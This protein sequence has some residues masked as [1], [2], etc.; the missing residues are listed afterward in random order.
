M[1]LF[2]VLYSLGLSAKKNYSLRRQKHLPCKVISLGNLTVGGTGK[3]PAAIAVAEEALKRGFSSVILTRGYK[4]SAKGPCFVSRGDVPLLNVEEAGD[5]PY[6]MAAR[7]R[8]VPVVKGADR[9]ASGLFAIKELAA[10]STTSKDRLLFILDDGFQHW[11]LYRDKDIV[12]IDSGDPFGNG[13]LLPLGRLREPVKAVGRA[14]IIVITKNA[15]RRDQSGKS[16]PV[17]DIIRQYNPDAPVHL[18]SHKTVSCRFS[19]GLR[20]PIDWLH[21]KKVLAF[22]GLGSPESFRKTLLLAGAEVAGFLT[23][24]DHYKY[25]A[26]DIADIKANAARTG[27]DWI[28]TTEKDIIKI[29]GLDLPDNILIIEIEFS[30]STNFYSDIFNGLQP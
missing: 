26:E 25:N 15:D 9:H 17:I 13:M 8:G 4:G 30:V 16:V 28:V 11:R 2:E 24:R 1:H 18:A 22:C 7:L 29:S 21:G 20:E 3:T 12:L 6:L 5:E 10:D 23:Y 14:D 19:S 27:A